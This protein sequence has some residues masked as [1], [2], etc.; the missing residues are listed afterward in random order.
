MTP[1]QDRQRL[2][3]F[4]GA[5]GIFTARETEAAGIHSQWLSRLVSEGALERVARGCYRLAGNQMTE[6]HTLAVVAAVTPSAVVC[7]LSALQF[8]Q[9]GTQAP[10]EVW[11]ALERSKAHPRLRYPPLRVVHFSGIAFTSGI[12]LHKIE[13]R[14]A[15]VYSV[16]KTVADCFKYRN[17]I[18]LD[19]ALEAL[20]DSWRQRRLSLQELNGFARINRVQRVIQP[21]VEALIQ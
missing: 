2:L 5:H 10:L 18:G 13:G 17:Q 19:V 11:I 4:A 1:S 12:E 7:L 15:R 3:D 9:I 20:T 8:H 21:Y 6:H 14:D 16:A